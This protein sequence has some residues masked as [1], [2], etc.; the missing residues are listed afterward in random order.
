MSQTIDMLDSLRGIVA[1]ARAEEQRL[2]WLL[3]DN[4]E[5][6]RAAAWKAYKKAA[7]LA[8]ELTR[9]AERYLL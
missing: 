1:K 8:E 7:D 5:P 9:A 2:L 3:P 6:G 4:G